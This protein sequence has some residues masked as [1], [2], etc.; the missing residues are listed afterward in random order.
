MK[1]FN[2]IKE[3]YQTQSINDMKESWKNFNEKIISQKEFQSDLKKFLANLSELIE[4]V[5]N[6]PIE[7]FSYTNRDQTLPFKN[8]KGF[9]YHIVQQIDQLKEIRELLLLSV[10]G[11]ER[12]P[13]DEQIAE[14]ASCGRCGFD[15]DDENC[16]R[17]LFCDIEPIMKRY[18][19]R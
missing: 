14:M 2:Q 15:N 12:Q 16:K 7:I 9:L 18:N 4:H 1:E 19:C 3:R 13:T 6:D 10:E 11:L 8:W 17:C 5:E